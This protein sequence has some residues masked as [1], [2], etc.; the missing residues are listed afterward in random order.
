MNKLNDKIPNTDMIREIN[1]YLMTWI[2]GF[3]IDRKTRGLSENTL[4]FYTRK[5]RQFNEFA[6]TQAVSGG[7][8]PD[9]PISLVDGNYR[10]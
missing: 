3:I 9:P 2:E 5:L 7:Y 6:E 8:K 10:S 1:D 4:L